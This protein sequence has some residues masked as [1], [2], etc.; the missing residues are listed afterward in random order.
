MSLTHSHQLT[1]QQEQFIKFTTTGHQ[2]GQKTEYCLQPR[3]SLKKTQAKPQL[4][5]PNEK[6]ENYSHND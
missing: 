6:L 5:G 1:A 4:T 2:A 3:I